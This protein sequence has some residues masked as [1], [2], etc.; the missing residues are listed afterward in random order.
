M[1]H[2]NIVDPQSSKNAGDWIVRRGSISDLA[3]VLAIADAA[4]TAAHWPPEAYRTFCVAEVEEHVSV[5]KVLFVAFAGQRREIVGFAAFQAMI[6]TGECGLENMAVGQGWRRQGIGR[7]LL[8]AGL[9]WCRGCCAVAKDVSEQDD[10]LWLEVRAS[11]REA[12]E[13]YLQA[14]FLQ[15]SRRTAYYAHPVED[16]LLMRKKL[17]LRA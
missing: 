3:G 16:A 12:I 11:N 7:R 8:A 13:F 2:V 15:I 10:N 17:Y 9:L 1:T 4:G 6:A 5:A 14:G